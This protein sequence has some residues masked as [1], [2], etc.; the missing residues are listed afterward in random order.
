MCHSVSYACWNIY[1]T[2][3]LFSS[4][5]STWSMFSN[6]SDGS[7]RYFDYSEYSMWIYMRQLLFL[8]CK[9]SYLFRGGYGVT[10]MRSQQDSEVFN[11]FLSVTCI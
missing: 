11:V 7:F 5:N 10:K 6:S 3:G 9:H 8:L 2:K 1:F 4:R